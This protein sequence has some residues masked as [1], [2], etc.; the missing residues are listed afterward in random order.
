VD[1]LNPCAVRAHA[2]AVGAS[3]RIDIV[4]KAVA[5]DDVQASDLTELSPVLVLRPVVKS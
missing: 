4:F 3:A 2:D 1:V 5:N